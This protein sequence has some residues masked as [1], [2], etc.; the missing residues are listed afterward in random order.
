M[1]IENSSSS[2]RGNSSNNVYEQNISEDLCFSLI[3]NKRAYNSYVFLWFANN[4]FFV[5]LVF[6]FVTFL[7]DDILADAHGATL[8][9]HIV[10]DRPV[11]VCPW[12]NRRT[13]CVRSVP[14]ATAEIYRN[15]RYKARFR[16]R[17]RFDRIDSEKRKIVLK[18]KILVLGASWHGR[19]I[20]FAYEQWFRPTNV[21]W[22]AADSSGFKKLKNNRIHE[23]FIV[24]KIALG[25][26]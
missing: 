16:F 5:L 9:S 4:N 7:P 18:G 25:S 13:K 2:W 6:N 26:R 24:G 15:K 21:F 22:N 17:W 3:T 8:T 14:L 10:T 20:K 23:R 19:S 11:C 1:H 12:R